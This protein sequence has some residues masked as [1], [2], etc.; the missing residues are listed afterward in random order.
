MDPYHEDSPS[1]H[2]N[3]TVSLQCFIKITS[4]QIYK[5]LFWE[6]FIMNQI[7]SSDYLGISPKDNKHSA[8]LFW[9]E[10]AGSL[11]EGKIGRSVRPDMPECMC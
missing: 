1:H 8:C 2:T 7:A 9:Q 3:S 10:G 6:N 4:G 11:F 5:S